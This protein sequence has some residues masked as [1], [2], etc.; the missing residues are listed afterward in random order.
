[1]TVHEKIAIVCG[2]YDPLSLQE[3]RFLQTCKSKADWLIVGIHSDFHLAANRGGY[4]QDYAERRSIIE[5]LSC[6]DEVFLFNDSDGTVSN[7]LKLVKVCYPKAE[8]YYVS[9]DDMHNAP[10]TRVRGITFVT[11]KQE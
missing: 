2:D 8:I 9:E 5:A 3:L 1:M 11:M 6:V 4:S 10:E 7:L